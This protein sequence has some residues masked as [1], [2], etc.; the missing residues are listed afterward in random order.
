MRYTTPTMITIRSSI[1]QSLIGLALL[2][3]TAI[4]TQ[5]AIAETIT[6]ELG[7][8]RAEISYTNSL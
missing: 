5:T 7:N 8:V 4:F 3:A 6:G 1:G 2:S